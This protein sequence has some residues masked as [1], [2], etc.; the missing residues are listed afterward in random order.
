VREYFKLKDRLVLQKM[1][2]I[3]KIM[4]SSTSLALCCGLAAILTLALAFHQIFWKSPDDYLQGNLV[5]IMYVHG[6][7]AWVSMLSYMV[8]ALCSA[9]YLL[10]RA[11]LLDMIAKSTSYL[12]L[13]FIGVTLITGA[14]WGK[15]AWG[16]WWVWDARLTSMLILFFITLA[17][18][19]IRKL[20]QD[21]ALSASL[22]AIV[23]VIGFINIPII[24]F[25]VDV[26]NTLHQKS[27]FLKFSGSSVHPAM[28]YPTLLVFLGIGLLSSAFVIS[29]VNLEILR[30]KLRRQQCFQNVRH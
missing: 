13:S 21:D 2:R 23:A 9:G 29:Q 26:W 4:I 3:L 1:M 5:K 19:F 22:S 16:T 10:R 15:P 14:A 24:K 6:P 12:T 20:Y 30:R 18:V 17:Y 7:C 28:L 25:S 27:S 8:V 11:V